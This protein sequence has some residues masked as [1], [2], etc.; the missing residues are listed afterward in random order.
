LDKKEGI[1]QVGASQIS[2][3]K[4]STEKV[5][6]AEVSALKVGRNEARTS[7]VGPS[8]VGS[9]QIRL[10]KVGTFEIL[11]PMSDFGPH[12]FA[13]LLQQSIDVSLVCR[14]VQM[15]QV[16]RVELSETVGLLQ[17]KAELALERVS[18]RQRQR[19]GQ[20]PEQL[21]QTLHNPEDVEHLPCCLRVSF[22][23]VPSTKSHLGDLLPGT[24]A[25]VHGAA[26]KALPS[27]VRMYTAAEVR[28]HQIGAGLPRA[29]ID[30]E[31]G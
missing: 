24:E 3:S 11:L 28:S 6:A 20:I 22:P 7:H 29:L 18:R 5:G 31:V 13:R 16:I 26:S 1:S 19:F 8:E 10:R 15:E 30:R 17:G 27:K 25:V 12:N 9:L 4:V 2:I 14:Q 21:M 23:P